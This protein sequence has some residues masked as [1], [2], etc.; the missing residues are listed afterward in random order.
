MSSTPSPIRRREISPGDIDRIVDLL[1]RGFRMHG[2]KR[3]FWERALARLSEHPTPAGYPKYGYLLECDGMPVGVT[4]MVY[5]TIIADGRPHIRCSM[6]SWYVEPA[7]RAYAGQLTSRVFRQ[8]EVTFCDT[9][10]LPSTFP[11]LQ[12]MGYERYC[13]GRFVAVP[14]LS[15]WLTNVRVRMVAPGIA[16]GEDLSAFETQLLLDH[17]NYGCVS[18]TCSAPG[19]RHPFVFQPRRKGLVAFAELVYCRDLEDFVRHAGPLGRFLALRGLPL[20][21]VDAND[22]I[23]GLIGRY[24]DGFPKY[25]RGPNRPRLGDLAYSERVLF[26][27]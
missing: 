13:S 18:V 3:Q 2:H 14:A 17:R 23:A 16:A 15:G 20:V 22:P 25:F 10:P 26:G 24:C 21:V 6:S 27:F 12:A 11:T 7:F 8:K 19:R 1:I 9:T 4:L 5:T